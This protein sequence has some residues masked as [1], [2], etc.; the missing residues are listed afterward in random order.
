VRD[1]WLQ[2]AVTMH[3]HCTTGGLGADRLAGNRWAVCSAVTSVS[4]ATWCYVEMDLVT[5]N[6]SEQDRFCLLI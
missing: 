6:L 1:R 5:I 4:A 2:R 3:E